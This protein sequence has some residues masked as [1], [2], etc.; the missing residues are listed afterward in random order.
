MSA[1]QARD[2]VEVDAVTAA[3]ARETFQSLILPAFM[4]RLY[5]E[6]AYQL[7]SPELGAVA[8][9]ITMAGR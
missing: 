7:I 6:G 5:A 1:L 9:P 2:I 3:T 8:K 4:T